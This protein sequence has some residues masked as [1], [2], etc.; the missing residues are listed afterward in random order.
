[1]YLSKK[2]NVVQIRR[3]WVRVNPKVIWSRVMK[4]S[5]FVT[6]T[7]VKS[8]HQSVS[9]P[10]SGGSKGKAWEEGADVLLLCC[11]SLFYRY[12]FFPLDSWVLAHLLVGCSRPDQPQCLNCIYFGNW[13]NGWYDTCFFPSTAT[14]V[15]QGPWEPCRWVSQSLLDHGFALGALD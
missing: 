7:T 4:Y 11:F 14:G 5:Y 15:R 10:V 9:Q 2:V 6:Y 8:E 1:M 13:R 3:T 12:Y